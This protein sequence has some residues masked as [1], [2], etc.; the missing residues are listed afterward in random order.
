MLKPTKRNKKQK[1][2]SLNFELQNIIPKTENQQKV[3]DL[4]DEGKN[5]FLYGCPGTGKCQGENV[6]VNLLV[7]D[8]LYEKLIKM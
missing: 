5:L 1:V 2:N 8:E 7:S 3:F 4:Y 6:E